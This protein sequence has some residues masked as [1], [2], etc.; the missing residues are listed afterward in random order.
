MQ[1]DDWCRASQD[2]QNVRRLSH[3]HA[4]FRSSCDQELVTAVG[5]D[6]FRRAIDIT[7]PALLTKMPLEGGIANAVVNEARHQFYRTAGATAGITL[8]FRIAGKPIANDGTEVFVNLYMRPYPPSPSPT[9]GAT[10]KVTPLASA[11]RIV[12]L[13]KIENALG[14]LDTAVVAYRS[15]LSELQMF[16]ELVGLLGLKPINSAQATFGLRLYQPKKDAVRRPHAL[17]HGYEDRFCGT[18]PFRPYGST[19]D[20]RTGA[21]GLPE[22]IAFESDLTPISPSAAEYAGFRTELEKRV[23]SVGR[24]AGTG[25]IE[26]ILDTTQVHQADLSYLQLQPILIGRLRRNR[27]MCATHGGTVGCLCQAGTA[28][29]VPAP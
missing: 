16:Q 9:G 8:D 23:P 24:A 5:L 3:L 22:A 27:K 17:S 15:Q 26:F 11:S 18:S 29:T 12:W 19:A 28:S 2:D 4:N 20:N 6:A 1:L 14:R 21:S 10:T 13:T 25:A 7:N